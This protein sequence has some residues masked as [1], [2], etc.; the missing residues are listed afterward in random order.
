MIAAALGATSLAYNVLDNAGITLVGVLVTFALLVQFAS[1]LAESERAPAA[2]PHRSGLFGTFVVH[3]RRLLE[4]LVDFAL[5]TAS[6]STAYLLRFGGSDTEYERDIFMVSLPVILASRYAV[7]LVFGLYSSVWRYAGARDA[8]GIVAAVALSEVIA[9]GFLFMTALPGFGLFS[10][11]VFVIDALL[12]MVLIGASRFGERGLLH[13]LG[14]LKD[15]RDRRRILIVGA[16]RGGRSL[17]RELHETPGEQVVG[18]VDDDPSLRRR[19]IHGVPVLGSAAE[20]ERVLEQA[21]P[22]TVLVTIP[23]AP[24]ERLDFVVAGCANAGVPCRFVR[25]ETNLDPDAVLGASR[26]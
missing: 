24:R 13:L 12:C 20:M 18:F 11:S 17:V 19:R 4:V 6:F 2:T 5:I 23:D 25:R 9:V 15:P 3:R 21:R 1:F 7:F 22:T 16:G 10:R 14:R 26:E 8:V